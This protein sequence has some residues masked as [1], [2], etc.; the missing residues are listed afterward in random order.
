M[1]KT[2]DACPGDRERST[3][4]RLAAGVVGSDAMKG[5]PPASET[6][7]GRLA[8]ANRALMAE[9]RMPAVRPA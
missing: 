5:M 3:V 2:D 6:T 9:A 8:T 7:S 4:E 1:P